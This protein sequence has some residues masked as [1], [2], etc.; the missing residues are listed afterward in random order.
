MKL[1]TYCIE[2]TE[3][4]GILNALENGIYPIEALGFNFKNMLEL[5]DNI[6][7]YDKKM[8]REKINYESI[9]ALPLTQVKLLAPIPRP[10][11]DLICLGGNYSEHNNEAAKFV[12][13]AYLKDPEP[14]IYFSKRVNEAVAPGDYIESHSDIV[15]D[16]DYEAELAVVI[17]K[18]ARNVKAEDAEKYIFGYTIVNDVSAR[19]I[20]LRHKQWYFGKSLDGFTPMGP[21]IV[22]ADEF[23]FPPRLKLQCKVN[24]ELRQ[25]SNTDR[26]ICTIPQ[27]IEEL[28]KGITLLP[29]TIIITGT[30]SGVG[31]ALN[32][33]KLLKAGDIVECI[34]EKIGNLSNE[35]K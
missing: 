20:Q 28:S 6:T 24:G 11:Q 33:P 12:D 17:G 4:I 22:T 9:D 2:G 10:S 32:P 30:P 19:T 31:L 14:T 34:I 1:V 15:K 26:M 23:A 16:L 21:S 7:T 18:K 13:D 27:V 35:I 25:N 5:I 29:G 3:K 8:L